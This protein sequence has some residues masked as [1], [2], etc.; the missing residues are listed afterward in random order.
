[1]VVGTPAW[2]APEQFTGSPVTP[3]ADIFA[4]GGLVAYAG[5]G[6]LPFGTGPVEVLAYRIVHEAPDLDGST[7]PRGGW[8]SGPWPR[9]RHAGRAPAAC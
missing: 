5:T 6:R 1:M 9:T 8:W 7:R 4:W 2:M 3:A